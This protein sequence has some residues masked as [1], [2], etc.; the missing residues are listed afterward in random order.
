MNET[1]EA[2]QTEWVN[3]MRVLTNFVDICKNANR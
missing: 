3:E 1:N 2:K